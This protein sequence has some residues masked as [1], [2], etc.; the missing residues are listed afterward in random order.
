MTATVFD[1]IRWLQRILVTLSGN[2]QSRIAVLD[3]LDFYVR[4]VQAGM[5]PFFQIPNIEFEQARRFGP[6]TMSKNLL[7][8]LG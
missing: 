7:E 6:A 2:G 5:T 1:N 3:K 8:M 4:K